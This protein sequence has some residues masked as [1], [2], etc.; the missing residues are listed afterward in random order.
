VDCPGGTISGPPGSPVCSSGPLTTVA[1]IASL[2]A[3]ACSGQL[4]GTYTPTSTSQCGGTGTCT[5]SD[6]AIAYGTAALGGGTVSSLTVSASCPV[7]PVQTDC[8]TN[9]PV[10]PCPVGA[11]CQ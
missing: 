1:T 4:S 8:P 3:G 9:P 2:A 11:T 5:L 7:C 10:A 6:Q